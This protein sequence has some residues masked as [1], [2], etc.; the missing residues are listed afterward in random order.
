MRNLMK[1]CLAIAVV[2]MNQSLMAQAQKEATPAATVPSPANVAKGPF[3]HP[4]LFN[5]REELD[6][7]KAK[8]AAREEP[9]FAALTAMA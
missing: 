2:A 5:S 4:G 7:I 8:V 6:F 1:C 3:R 9:W